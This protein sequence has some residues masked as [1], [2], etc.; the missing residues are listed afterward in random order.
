M[1]DFTL[2]SYRLVLSGLWH[3]GYAFA[4]FESFLDQSHTFEKVIILRHDVDKR[5]CN[6]LK[7][8]EIEHEMGIQ[9]S[10]YFRTVKGSFNKEVIKKIIGMRHEIGYHYENLSRYQGNYELAIN[11]FESD[12]NKIR[13]F[14]PVK[15]I[16]MHGSPLSKWDN[17]DLWNKYDYRDYGLIGEPYFDIDFEKVL[18]LTDTGRRWDGDKVSVRDKVKDTGVKGQELWVS[19][20]KL[21]K[22]KDIIE[23]A[24]KELLPKQILINTH[25]QR[26]SDDSVSWVVELTAQNIKNLIKQLWKCKVK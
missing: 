23:A 18:Y 14:Y 2:E 7:V 20:L 6:A 11:N 4:T 21:R 22:T 12:L 25:P 8:A 3:A 16:C 9:A 15:T 26:W 17:R 24:V 13:E 1:R 19:K 5:P 10:Y